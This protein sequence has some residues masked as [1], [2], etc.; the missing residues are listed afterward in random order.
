ML[1]DLFAIIKSA[2][3]AIGALKDIRPR[4]ES[5]DKHVQDGISKIL[6]TFYFAPHGILSLLKEVA[7]GEKPT[8]ARLQQALV[9]FNDRQW[10][11]EG[12]I[13]GLEYGALER[14]LGLSL[15]SILFLGSLRE[16]KIDLRHTI[17]QE[18]NSYGQKGKSPNRTK[19][20]KLITAIE[21][22]NAAI[23]QI[24]AA[25]RFID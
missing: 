7:D 11:I 12:A 15:T 4:Q 18:V 10:K 2:T 23:R 8:S 1:P 9:D 19:V 3:G 5:R 24:E 17:Q 6:R 21:E 25:P 22:L 14:E 13:A 20:R 16:G